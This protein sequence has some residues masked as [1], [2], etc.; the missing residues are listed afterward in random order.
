M[1]YDIIVIGAGLGGLV[2]AACFA[3]KGKKVLVLEQH[4]IPG[5]CATTFQRKGVTCEVGLHEMDFGLPHR[6]GKHVIFKKLGLDKT[7]PIVPLPEFFRLK[8]SQY[9]YTIPE[10]IE[11]AKNY[12]KQEFPHEKAGI[13]A[14]FRD[15]DCT[16]YP[17]RRL[18]S[19]LDPISFFFFPITSFPM[20]LKTY[21]QQANV[22]QK[23][24]KYFTDNKLKNLLNGNLGY[25]ADD[26]YELS[27]FYH[28]AAQASYFNKG[29][30]I[31]GGSQVLS[32][33]L[34]DIIKQH[35]GEVRLLADVQKINMKGNKATGVVYQDRKTKEMITV[36]AK[37]LIA[38][39]AP[40]CIFNGHMVPKEIQ[41]PCID[42]LEI[43]TSL[44]S[45][46][47]IFKQKISKLYPGNS[48]STFLWD[49][50]DLNQPLSEIKNRMNLDI[51]KRGFVFVDY[52]A[53]DSG[54]VPEGDDR[55]FGV[56][57]STSKMKE[58]EGLSP[59]EYKAKKEK[60]ITGNLA[61]LEKYYP[62]IGEQIEYI[63][64]STPKTAHRYLKTPE[65]TAYG[66][67]Q[68]HYLKKSRTPRKSKVI[69][70]MFYASSWGFPGG[71]FTGAMISG[72]MTAI[73][74]FM[75]M[76]WRV[77]IGTILCAISGTIIARAHDWLP[78]LIYILSK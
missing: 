56:M 22:G 29:V 40:H 23:M 31:K 17:I 27:W 55:S 65:G 73:E 14:Y 13:D 21:F 59:E 15:L 11:N 75:P 57:C 47:I 60:V 43:E 16:T 30:F 67:K 26:P 62:G 77:L 18:P 78:E 50:L 44:Y 76:K 19:D 12:L 5:G 36:D 28:A 72:Y 68:N 41:E 42:K 1:R 70:N 66:F 3:K 54:L 34:T 71:G 10:G 74:Y 24:D 38:N 20:F 53:I 64:M 61:I 58:W 48:Y 49:G 35:G 6:D 39:C 7:L 4:N 63:E 69:K 2:S 52:S 51:E 8:S 33:Q 37:T 9:E 45:I 32:N 25:Y 46:Y